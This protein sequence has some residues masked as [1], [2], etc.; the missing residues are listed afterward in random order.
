[1][2]I[3]R[4]GRNGFAFLANHLWKDGTWIDKTNSGLEMIT[5]DSSLT[6]S[7]EGG[8]VVLVTNP[9]TFPPP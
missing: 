1:V 5:P 9:R 4:F 3:C 7:G 6:V 2:G 8:P